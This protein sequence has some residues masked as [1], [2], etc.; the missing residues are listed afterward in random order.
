MT[1]A[2]DVAISW[3]APAD[4]ASVTGYTVYRV[5]AGA[6]KTIGTQIV[7]TFITDASPVPGEI[8]AY[9]VVSIGANGKTSIHSAEASI[10]VPGAPGLP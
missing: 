3:T 4:A 5:V 6:T 2:N 8:N 9:S 1:A 10:T 7:K